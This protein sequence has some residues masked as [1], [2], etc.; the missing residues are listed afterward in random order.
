MPAS[1]NSGIVIFKIIADSPA[2]AAGL[3][4]GDI[5]THINGEPVH[6]SKDVYSHL[7][8]SAD[9]KVKVVRKGKWLEAMVK[10]ESPDSSS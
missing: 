7:E 3:M 4:P 9:L 2:D 10:P 6:G 5:I 8:G 1:V